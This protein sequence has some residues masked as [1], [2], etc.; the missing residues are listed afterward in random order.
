MN[1]NDLRIFCVAARASTLSAA[2]HRLG[3]SV[4]TVGRRIDALERSVGVRLLDRRPAG[5]SLT[6]PGRTLLGRATAAA[7]AM[8]DVDRLASTLG[9]HES[10][11]PIRVSATEP[12]ICDILAPALP[13]LLA[14]E[15]TLRLDLSAS[16]D[17]VSLAAREA[18][19]AVRFAQPL[20]DSLVARRLPSL[21]MGL[22]ASRAYLAGREPAALDLQRERLLG[23]DDSYGRIAEVV[24][25]ED[26][27]LSSAI[28][29]RSSSTRA[30][31]NAT[32]AGVGIALLPRLLAGAR[33]ELIELPAPMPP[34]SRPVWVVTHRDLRRVRS[35]RVVREWIV[36]AFR[37]ARVPR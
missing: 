11:P 15:P 2:A 3:L 30:L 32:E 26:A 27:G 34:P 18:D 21:A 29:V 24:W 25:M 1:W 16:T 28:A 12:F 33:R 35:L 31:L 4:A 37:A 5:I 19:V 9:S 7:D 6:E 17:V 13:K 23:F 10:H 14:V 8:D 22:F 36:D 20:G